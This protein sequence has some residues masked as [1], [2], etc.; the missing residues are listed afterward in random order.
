MSI[1]DIETK[2]ASQYSKSSKDIV[3]P[4][5]EGQGQF[6][7]SGG[8]QEVWLAF[9][10]Y[11][12]EQSVRHQ[13]YVNYIDR[14]VLPSL[15]N[16]KNDIKALLKYIGRDKDLRTNNLYDDR[17]R[18]DTLVSK[19]DRIIQADS[20]MADRAYQHPDPLLVNCGT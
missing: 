13:D 19:L 9:R 6:M 18:M 20:Q 10:N 1:E 3:V 15:R 17:R 8:I 5:P 4:F 16:I 14:S 2:S 11:T 12:V 7:Q